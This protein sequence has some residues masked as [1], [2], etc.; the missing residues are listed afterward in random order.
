MAPLG[1]TFRNALFSYDSEKLKEVKVVLY[2]QN[3]CI[4][5]LQ[6]VMDGESTENV[7]INTDNTA[8]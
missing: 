1:G 5:T 8:K 7:I 2:Q 6:N 4:N 3:N